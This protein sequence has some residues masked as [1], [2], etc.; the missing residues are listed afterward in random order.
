MKL[1]LVSRR[2]RIRAHRERDCRGAGGSRRD[3]EE[4]ADC[5]RDD[6]DGRAGGRERAS[7]R[8]R[9]CRGDSHRAL[10]FSRGWTSAATL[11]GD[12]KVTGKNEEPLSLRGDQSVAAEAAGACSVPALLNRC[13]MPAPAAQPITA[14]AIALPVPGL[15]VMFQ[16][17]PSTSPIEL[18]SIIHRPQYRVIRLA[19]SPSGP[20]PL[21]RSACSSFLPERSAISGPCSA[22]TTSATIPTTIQ[23]VLHVQTS[24]VMYAPEAKRPRI[25]IPKRRPIFPAT[26]PHGIASLSSAAPRSW[27]RHTIRTEAAPT[28]TNSDSR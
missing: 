26:R 4:G 10:L 12:G 5:E 8:G 1:N 22:S 7:A 27:K 6:D 20:G 23:P 24:L 14:A 2:R 11:T 3:A 15:V 25:A 21:A 13:P 16:T 17:T 28:P 9:C 18:N 19:S